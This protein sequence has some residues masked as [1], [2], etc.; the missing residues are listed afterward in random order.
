MRQFC[1]KEL[2]KSDSLNE[3]R[4]YISITSHKPR[5]ELIFFGIRYVILYPAFVFFSVKGIINLFYD[6]YSWAIFYGLG[7]L[8]MRALLKSHSQDAMMCI[9]SAGLVKVNNNVMLQLALLSGDTHLYDLS[10]VNELNPS[11]LL[12]KSRNKL[13]TI[14]VDDKLYIF[15]KSLIIHDET[16][17]NTLEKGTIKEYVELNNLL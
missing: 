13:R 4:K 16:L 14:S 1:Q 9:K 12:F 11:Q 5:L 8:L 10:S 7:A 3:T 6:C 2:P 15:P 17:L